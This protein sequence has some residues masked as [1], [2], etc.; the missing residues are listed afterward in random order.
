M[1]FVKE[2]EDSFKN[3]FQKIVQG[4]ALTSYQTLNEAISNDDEHAAWMI[5]PFL[6][7]LCSSM[8]YL[9]NI[10]YVRHPDHFS[11]DISLSFNCLP[12]LMK[13]AI[14]ELSASVDIRPLRAWVAELLGVILEF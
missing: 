9:N 14:F 1:L 6:R 13:F 8:L 7:P 10:L 11:I 3:H 4:N 2:S 5:N 12:I